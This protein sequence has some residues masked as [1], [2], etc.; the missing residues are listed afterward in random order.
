MRG[1][2][3]HAAN[4]AAEARL[5]PAPDPAP[6]P[7]GLHRVNDPQSP[8][9]VTPGSRVS[10]RAVGVQSRVAYDPAQAFTL[11]PWEY[12]F[13]PDNVGLHTNIGREEGFPVGAQEP[14]ASPVR[15]VLRSTPP[16]WYAPYREGAA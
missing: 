11:A 8:V 4:T 7:P 12:I 5:F 16:A 10:E 14:F 2:G 13:G 1:L 9:V 15:V 6:D 3:L